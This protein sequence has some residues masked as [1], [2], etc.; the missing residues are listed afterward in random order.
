MKSTTAAPGVLGP[1][2]V[3]TQVRTIAVATDSAGRVRCS[4]RSLAPRVNVEH[5]AEQGEAHPRRTA[6]DPVRGQ[7]RARRR[8]PAHR[9]RRQ[10]RCRPARCRAA[11]RRPRECACS[12][13]ASDHQAQPVGVHDG[14]EACREGEAGAWS[15]R[16]SSSAERAVME[17]LRAG[18]RNRS[19]TASSSPVRLQPGSSPRRQILSYRDPGIDKLC[20]RR[21]LCR[22]ACSG[23]RRRYRAR[24]TRE[25]APK[26]AILSPR[27]DGFQK[28]RSFAAFVGVIA[29]GSTGAD[30]YFVS[31]RVIGGV[32]HAHP[33]RG[34]RDWRSKA[35][36][37]R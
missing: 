16:S 1:P 3:C 34:S 23:A 24:P 5:R 6:P 29:C 2:S 9:R 30:S 4:R 25:T 12:P 17:R 7:V 14:S 35:V 11:G 20:R 13:S 37:R 26:R 31:F 32:V 19:H 28:R 36:R 15:S 10:R 22:A 18:W 21:H 27:V 33:F 8:G